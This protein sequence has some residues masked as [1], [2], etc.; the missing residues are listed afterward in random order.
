MQITP[1]EL[2][3]AALPPDTCRDPRA[4]VKEELTHM[5]RLQKRI[6][7][8]RGESGF[9]LIEL[10]VVIIII[11]I[12]LAIALPSF[13]KVGDRASESDAKAN[14][15]ASFPATEAYYADNNTYAA[16]TLA[17]NQESYDPGI[18][19]I[20]FGSTLSATPSC[21]QAIVGQATVNK[22]GPSA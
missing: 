3:V 20:P 12:L 22:N 1:M 5:Q 15:R 11:G 19:N 13:Q 10:L 14:A 16:H 17:G 9:T 21:V 18:K 2:R 6:A 4:N 8:G 7:K